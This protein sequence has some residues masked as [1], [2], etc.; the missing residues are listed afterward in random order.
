MVTTRNTSVNTT[1]RMLSAISF[2]VLR[3]EAPSTILIMRSRKVSPGCAVMRTTSQSDNTLVPP[4]TALRSPAASRITG[5]LSP[6]IALSS[7]EAMPTT[8]SPSEGM[9]SPACTRT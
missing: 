1:S 2:G 7:T 3:R 9:M 8:A 5:A 6:V 4:V